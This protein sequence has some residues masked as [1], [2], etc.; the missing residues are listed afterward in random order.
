MPLLIQYQPYELRFKFDAGT[1]RG[2]LSK[3]TS[4]FIRITDHE[5][6][7]VVGFGECGPLPGLSVDDAPDFEA[8]LREICTLFNSL[9][10]EIFPFNLPILLQQL[11]PP[12]FPSIRFGIE[13]ALLDFLNGGEKIQFVNDFSK[14][15]KGITINGLVWMGSEDH[16][17]QQIEEKVSLG[18]TTIKMKVGALDFE[19]ECRL[20]EMIRTRYPKD[21]I[22]V[23]VDANGAFSPD[24][25]FE[26]LHRLHAYDLH[27]IEQ[28]IATGQ[29][30][31]LAE[32]VANSPVAVA[33][34][35]ELIGKMDYMQKFALL[36]RVH[37]PYIILKPTLLGGFQQCKEWIE[38]A[39]RLSIGWWITSALESNLGLNS[40]AQFTAQYD[41]IL[42]QGLGTGQLYHNNLPS[43]L[44]IR[45]GKLYSNHDTDWDLSATGSQLDNSLGQPNQF[46]FSNN[47]GW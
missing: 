4:W 37:P 36:K 16:M 43:P 26:K 21:E 33:L 30:D 2:V 45:E 11:I 38:I 12:H 32:V 39:Q 25:V 22:A 46:L 14:N 7:G 23:R 17:R 42:P 27:S 15:G 41:P 6:P 19:Q 13:T 5:Q 8:K 24:T 3:K 31:L 28:P 40:I 34:D 44:E 47:S 18:Y 9:D 29:L 35:E 10:L 1:S 20:L